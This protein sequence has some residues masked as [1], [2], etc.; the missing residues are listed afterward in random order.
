M[1]KLQKN[2]KT[3]APYQIAVVGSVP[4]NLSFKV[5]E[6]HAMAVLDGEDPHTK[7]KLDQ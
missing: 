4:G 7:R 5:S 6:I 3:V 2:T 1:P